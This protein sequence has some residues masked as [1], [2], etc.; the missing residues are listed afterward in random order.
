MKI[1]KSKTVDSRLEDK[2][3]DEFKKTISGIKR[4]RFTVKRS[5]Q[6]DLFF[7]I[8]LLAAVII[9]GR[10]LLLIND[11]KTMTIAVTVVTASAVVAAIAFFTVFKLSE[12]NK[13]FCYYFSGENGVTCVSVIGETATIFFGGTAYRIEGEKFYTQGERYF[14][15]FLDGECSGLYSALQCAR[16]DFELISVKGTKYVAAVL[17]EYGCHEFTVVDGKIKSVVSRQPYKTDAVDIKT[18]MA[19]IKTRAYIKKE[20]TGDFDFQMPAFITEAFK[21]AG[22]ELPSVYD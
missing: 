22:A 21:K 8:M 1:K 17:G 7:V 19:V 18:G 5:R 10:I 14:K 4:A 15:E 11:G 20:Y 16:D 3:F 13:K 2:A 12:R 9:A 6:D